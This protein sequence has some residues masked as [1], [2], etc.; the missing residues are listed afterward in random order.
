[1][2]NFL[3]FLGVFF[4]FTSRNTSLLGNEGAACVGND[5]LSTSTLR[6]KL[7]AHLSE[8]EE[9]DAQALHLQPKFDSDEPAAG[10]IKVRSRGN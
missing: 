3:C 8:D 5:I 6:R 7:F 10:T 4:S 9:E 2:A 1:M